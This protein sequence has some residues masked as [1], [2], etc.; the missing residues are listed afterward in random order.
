[1][2][3]FFHPD[4][5]AIGACNQCGKG[6]CVDCFTED[7]HGAIF[8]SDCLIN[9]RGNKEIELQLRQKRVTGSMLTVA[10]VISFIVSA[11]GTLFIMGSDKFKHGWS[12]DSRIFFLVI[13]GSVIAISAGITM[14]GAMISNGAKM[15]EKI[16]RQAQES[17]SGDLK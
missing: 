10:G 16:L 2:K 5:D 12:S 15:Q 9:A 14:F 11:F 7:E 6:A 13:L 1:M 8:H 3:C 17:E 4:K